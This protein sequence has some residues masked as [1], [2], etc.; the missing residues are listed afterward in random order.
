MMLMCR[1]IDAVYKVY[2]KACV[3]NEAIKEIR[4]GRE[5]GL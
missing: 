3:I 2:N 4:G 1:R 5:Y